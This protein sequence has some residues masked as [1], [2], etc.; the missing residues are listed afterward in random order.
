M[1][2]IY[3]KHRKV[4]RQLYAMPF[5]DYSHV[6]HKGIH[7]MP[8][9]KR[10][11]AFI[12]LRAFHLAHRLIPLCT[13]KLQGG[14]RCIKLRIREK[15]GHPYGRPDMVIMGVG[16]KNMVNMALATKRRTA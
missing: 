14:L 11:N 3:R 1:A 7:M 10:R 5:L 15:K 8:F 13:R 16:K 4:F 9:E 2:R 12:L 6:F